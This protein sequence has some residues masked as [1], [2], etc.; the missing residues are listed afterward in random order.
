MVNQDSVYHEYVEN[1]K[2]T[3]YGKIIIIKSL[4]ISQ[5]VYAATVIHVPE[6]L[7]RK[8]EKMIRFYGVL[9]EKK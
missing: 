1:E 2:L 6:M 9:K 3:L 8:L 7:A 4:V 5:I